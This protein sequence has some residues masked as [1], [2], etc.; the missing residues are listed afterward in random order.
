M[1]ETDDNWR[2]LR[3]PFGEAT[4]RLKVDRKTY[5]RLRAAYRQPRAAIEDGIGARHGRTFP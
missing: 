3:G 1:T 2:P 4:V 5:E